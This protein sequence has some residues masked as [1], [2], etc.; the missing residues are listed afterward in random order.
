MKS[1]KPPENP[2]LNI[3]INII[4]PVFVLN[5]LGKH[6]D[7]KLTLIVALAF[8]LVYGVQDY[9]RRHHKNYVSLLGVINILM[10]GGLALM[11]LEGHWFAVK[12]AALPFVL[13]LFVLGSRW[14]KNP[15]ARLIF[16]NPQVLNMELIGQKLDEHRR[17]EDFQ[18]LLERTTLWLSLS[19]F[20]SAALNFFIALRVFVAIDPALDMAVREQV[21]NE[22][23]ARMTWMGFAV[24]AL[25]LMFFSAALVFLFLKRLSVMTEMPVNSLLKS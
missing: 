17:A 4:L 15:A 24:I 25:P 10:T 14:S 9:I 3:L 2:L 20:V 11:A 22:Q 7:P 13:G 12:E 5:K 16:C 18:S 6:L 23:I 1:E 21:L 19:F 8:P